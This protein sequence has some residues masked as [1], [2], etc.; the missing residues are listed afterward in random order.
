MF[1]VEQRHD[2]V[3]VNLV[4]GVSIP[5][6][7]TTKPQALDAAQ[8]Q[9]LREKLVTWEQAPALG[10]A[11]LQELHE[12]ADFLIHTGLRPGE[13]FALRWD[14]VDMKATPPTVFVNATV[15]RTSTGGV[16]IQDHP[17]SRHGVRLPRARFSYKAT[18]DPTRTAGE[19]CI[20]KSAWT[21]VS[22]VHGNHLRSKQHRQDVAQ[23]VRRF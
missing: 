12:I 5:L 20:P 23:G 6:N 19:K 9:D 4:I 3:T 14:D 8:Y 22:L 17:K 11:R 18:P 15:I 16:R 13:L 21:C 1:K 10:S 2:A 7:R